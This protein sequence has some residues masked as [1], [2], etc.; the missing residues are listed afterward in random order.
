MICKNCN[1]SFPLYIRVDGKL[2][3]LCKRSYCLDCSPF[4]LHNTKAFGYIKVAKDIEGNDRTRECRVCNKPYS[5][6]GTKC[7]S[8]NV[9]MRR[10]SIKQKCIDYKGG[11]CER[12]G[13]DK[14]PAGLTFHHLD[15]KEKDFNI[16]NS[17]CRAFAKIKSELDKC[18][19]LCQ[20]CHTEEHWN[21]NNPKRN[22]TIE[23]WNQTPSNE[24]MEQ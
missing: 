16:S 6:K 1:N 14:C 12:C 9:N 7:A 2:R 15:P 18:I 21:Q 13:Y 20:N 23:R 17:H 8:C 5:G 24:T 11:R 4:G 19:M 22:L 10:F 3:N